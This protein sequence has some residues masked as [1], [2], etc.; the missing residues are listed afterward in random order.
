MKCNS[1]LAA[2]GIA[3][4]STAAMA[5]ESSRDSELEMAVQDA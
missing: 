4:I 1:I 2:L 5:Q 3:L